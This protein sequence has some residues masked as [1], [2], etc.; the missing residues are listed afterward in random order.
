MTTVF[1]YEY[2]C[3]QAA[4]SSTLAPSLL[5]EGRA[6]RDAIAADFGAIPE[7]DVLLLAEEDERR[8]RDLAAR[9]DFSFVVAPE[10][11]RILETRC[12]WVEE[13]GGKWLGPTST[14]IRLVA[15]KWELSRHFK[16]LQ[17][18]A[19]R[20]WLLDREPNDLYPIVLKPRFGAGSQN[21]FLL[22]SSTDRPI[23]S[24]ATDPEMIA[25]EYVDGTAASV[26]FLIG[27]ND[28]VALEPCWQHL[29]DD[30]RFHYLGGSLPIPP[31]LAERAVRLGR[32]AVNAVPGLIGYIGVDLVLGSQESGD[33]VVEINPRLTTSYIGLRRLAQF[34]IAEIVLRVVRGEPIPKL[35]WNRERVDFDC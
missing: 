16:S 9:A 19:P 8:F 17:V 3:A 34:N 20:T 30:G 10:F 29:S 33:R 7:V 12:R 18:P 22:H 24:E 25:Q 1:V 21:T 26:A 2:L 14:A 13:A 4:R 5:R 31:E 15:D 6:M 28:C 11:E 27:P 23:R 35:E 32:R